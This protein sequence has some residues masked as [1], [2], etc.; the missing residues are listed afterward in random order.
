MKIIALEE[1]YLPEFLIK[2]WEPTVEG[3]AAPLYD[4]IKGRLLDSQEIRR[5]KMQSAGI[6]VMVMSVA[7]PG[8]QA[9]P[10]AATA[11]QLARRANDEL[12]DL[13]SS[14][15]SHFAGFAHLPMQSGQAA[16]DELERSVRD[17]NFCGALVNGHTQG[18]YLDAPEYEVFW[19]RSA[20]LGVPIY[21]H[22]TDPPEKYLPLRDQPKLR[23]PAW[24]WTV[25]TAT[26]ALRLVFNDVFVRHPGAQVILGHMG[27][28]LP[29][30]LWRFDSR[31]KFLRVPGEDAPMPS[32][33]IRKNFSVTISGMLDMAP[34]NCAID[35]IGSNS[36]MFG[37]DYPFEDPEDAVE[38]IKTA[39]VSDEIRTK[40]ASGNAE[41]VLGLA[42]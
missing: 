9:E 29:Y 14:D 26:H 34:L 31:A 15:P 18:K 8:V 30:L 28:T 32:E 19:E 39:N 41:R 17:L 6:D 27:E 23:R 16:A 12:A 33:I 10:D 21:I 20:D 40:I 42:T 2:Y 13:I 25:E 5:Q 11:I 1:H 35:A 4:K 24:E 7:G 37:A 38:F 22:P 3:M 36:I